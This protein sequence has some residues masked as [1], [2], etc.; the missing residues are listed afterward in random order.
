MDLYNN[1]VGRRLALDP[2]NRGRQ[3]EEVIL[4]AIQNGKLQTRPFRF[5]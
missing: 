2:A 4:E 1:N 5:K 3:A